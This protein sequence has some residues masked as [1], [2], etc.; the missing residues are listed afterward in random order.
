MYIFYL[1]AMDFWPWN[2]FSHNHFHCAPQKNASHRESRVQARIK[3]PHR[4]LADTEL[5]SGSI[6]RHELAT[7]VS[8]EWPKMQ[9]FAPFLILSTFYWGFWLM[10]AVSNAPMRLWSRF[11][12][13]LG[14]LSTFDFALKS[15]FYAGITRVFR[16]SRATSL[17]KRLSGPGSPEKLCWQIN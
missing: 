6:C 11:P 16:P 17:S 9:C 2:H 1:Q 7:F 5:E 4:I 15:A 8:I 13:A 3:R 12:L 10:I 14:Q